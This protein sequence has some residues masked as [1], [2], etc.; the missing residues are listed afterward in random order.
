ME[1]I[2]GSYGV[3]REGTAPLTH[4]IFLGLVVDGRK[5]PRKALLIL[6]LGRHEMILGQLWLKGILYP[7]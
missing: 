3:T 4:T 5:L 2:A 6:K 7:P 1:R